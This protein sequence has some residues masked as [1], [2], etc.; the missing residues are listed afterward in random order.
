MLIDDDQADEPP[1]IVIRNPIDDT[2][3]EWD[4][5]EAMWRDMQA[6]CTASG[7]SIE[8]MIN[9]ALEDF[10]GREKSEQV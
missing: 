5:P 6:F 9:K 4:V 3:W 7:L 2:S 10:F 8:Q 1:T